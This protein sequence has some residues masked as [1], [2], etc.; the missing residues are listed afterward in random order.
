VA[1]EHGKTIPL[2]LALL[3]ALSGCPLPLDDDDATGDDDDATVDD[4][5][6]SFESPCAEPW[7]SGPRMR[8][9]ALERG[10]DIRTFHPNDIG[11]EI[12]GGHA[13][14]VAADLDGDGDT[15]LVTFTTQSGF[16]AWENDGD[17]WFEPH[18][19]FIPMDGQPGIGL[20]AVDLDGDRLPE[21]IESS[22]GRLG[23]FWNEG[24]WTWGP[25]QLIYTEPIHEMLIGTF[26]FGDLDLDGDLDLFVPVQADLEEDLVHALHRVFLQQEPLVWTERAVLQGAIE[27]VDTQSSALADFDRNGTMDVV[28]PGDQGHSSAVFANMG[29][30]REGVPLFADVTEQSGW[31][32]DFAAMGIDGADAN[33][34]GVLDWLVGDIG[35]PGLL[36]S[37]SGG[38][39]ESG[40]AMGVIPD[41]W[42][43]VDGTVGWTTLWRDVDND[44]RMD[45]LQSSAPHATDTPLRDIVWLQQDDGTWADRTDALG[46]VGEDAHYGMATTDLDGDGWLDYVATGMGQTPFLLMNTC[47]EQGWIELEFEGPPGNS[48]GW[49]VLVEMEGPHGTQTRQLFNLLGQAQGPPVLHFGLGSMRRAVDAVVEWPDGERSELTGLA[50]FQRHRIAHPSL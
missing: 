5:D 45:I 4:D 1:V 24:D 14:L 39:I 41:V 3:L 31:D 23:I 29:L 22:W 12:E 30:S 36:M 40:D 50:P 25:R 34:D 28:F 44:G 47:G 20:A 35:P 15:D 48:E 9:E 32:I 2:I 46:F 37:A 13:S 11:Q 19:G 33:G 7:T 21:I 27:M 49:G 18:E 26:N 38:F 43:D 17:A 6:D 16:L 8:D 42:Q 10:L